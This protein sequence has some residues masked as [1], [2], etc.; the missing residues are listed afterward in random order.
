[1]SEE[2]V[3]PEQHGVSRREVIAG[4]AGALGAAALAGVGA[5]Q[6]GQSQGGQATDAQKRLLDAAVA[7][8][9]SGA[10]SLSDVEHVVVLMQEN[11]SF[12]QY[13]GTLSGVRGF[14][15][16]AV[17]TQTVGGTAY[18]VYNQFGFAP[19]IGASATGYLQPFRLVSNPPLENGQTTNDVSH[20]WATQHQSWNDGAMDAFI[21]AHL[22]ADG[23][24]NGPVTMGYYTRQDLAFYHALADAFTICDGYHCSVLG[25]TDPNRLMLMSASI[26]PEGTHGGPV[27]E[28]FGNRIAETGKLSWE[29]M[30][31][32]LLAA[33]VSWKVYND[34][35]GLPALSPLP[36][37]K[38]YDDPFSITGLEL[39]GRGLTPNYPADFKADIAGGKLP[40]V[41]WIIP[42]VAECEHPAAPPYYGEYFVQQVLAAL[43]SNP[44]VW[45]RTVVFVV[46]DENGGFFDHVTP[47]TAPQG[48]AGEWLA[49]LPSAAGGVDGPIGLGFRTPALVISPFSAGGFKYSGTLDHTSVLR[50]IETRFG[51]TVPNLSDWR[52]GVTGDFTGALNLSAPANPAFPT[53]PVVSIGDT[54]VAEQ[55]VLNAL[56]G[57]LDV[58]IPYPL[59]TS[60]SMPV[61]ESSPARPEVP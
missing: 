24:T 11:R 34:P 60:N 35:I 28:T 16:P 9:A 1:M 18:P 44:D 54:S 5:A 36:Y 49:V 19:G 55:A 10:A 25:P 6:G 59:P 45:A 33:G 13:F 48:T 32:R 37:F 58:G 39:I 53:L 31:E 41:S 8:S 56:A 7:A 20:S 29:T 2:S 22:A 43:V 23:A 51:V 38:N 26:D 61:Q 15:D 40:S 57:T 30:P 17:P 50:F 3:R 27:V 4:S 21:T 47:P 46:Y 12:D 52:R 14:S 42:P